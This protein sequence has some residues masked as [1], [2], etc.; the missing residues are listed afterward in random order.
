MIWLLPVGVAAVVA[1][2]ILLSLRRVA[3]EARLLRQDVA[4]LVD[5][6]EP[7]ADLRASI[8]A[9]RGDIPELRGRTR[10]GSS[11]DP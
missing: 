4:A 10:P 7:V 8:V 9:L 5:L 11:A 2:P 1:L 3:R 6:R